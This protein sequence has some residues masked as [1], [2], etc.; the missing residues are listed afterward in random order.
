MINNLKLINWRT[1]HHTELEFDSGTNL[2]IGIMG[3]GKSSIVNALSYGLFG[4]FPALKSKQISLKE[5]IMNRPN[6]QDY[7][8]VGI[9]FT[10]NEKKYF[11]QRL[12]KD[13]GTNQAKLF[14]DNKLIA[15]PKQKDVNEKVEQI[16][17]L[18]YELF[19]RAVYAEQ[20]E[21]DF[22][23]KLNPSERKK[24][25]DELLE[26][27]KYE[28]VRK[29]TVILKN[30]MQKEN[31]QKKEFLIQQKQTIN[32]SEEEKI[33][34]QI[35]A[36]EKELVEINNN[37]NELINIVK[38]AQ[39][40]Y[41]KIEQK[42][43]LFLN[44]KMEIEVLKS[45]LNTLKKSIE[46]YDNNELGFIKKEINNIT[47]FIIERNNEK[48][49]LKQRQENTQASKKKLIEQAS[50]LSYK[51][52]EIEKEIKEITN[53][54]GTCPTCK[55]TLDEKHKKDL[56]NKLKPEIS[57][58][59]EEQNN[60]QS[61]NFDLEEINTKLKNELLKVEKE[62]EGLIKKEYEFEEKQRNIIKNER[63]IKESEITQ[64]EINKKELEI[65]NFE[66]SEDELVNKQNLYFELKNISKLNEEKIKSKNQLK[67]NLEFTL[68]KIKKMNENINLI[69]KEI[70]NSE[71]AI[72]KLGVFENCLIS[73]QIELREELL[74]TI[75]DAL[76]NVW[77]QI[78]PY[79][80][81]L[82]ICLK[83]VENGYDLQV[84]TRNGEWIRVEGILSGGERSAAAIC[85][86]I[87]FS[88]VLTKQLSMLIL[89]EPTHNLDS[90]SIEKLSKMLRDDLPKLVDQIFVITHEKE[91]ETASSAKIYLLNRNKD[92]DEATK[93]EEI[94]TK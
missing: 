19:S 5:I 43:K 10:H 59:V 54:V 90:N 6:K 75:N 89:D 77:K 60:I 23:L 42:Q 48:Q 25:F 28:T 85:I 37:Q 51:E 50:V 22:F 40:D 83:V 9:G 7:T 41:F 64:I 1:H 74:Q 26:L 86:R 24:K 68:N 21:M 3:S 32:D 4:T 47:N 14:E 80:D 16:L 91:L 17:G 35:S 49:T 52:K 53:L 13:E 81:Y 62:L 8:E 70:I 34:Q 30:Q 94:L 58:I 61:K 72:E 82:D 29:N 20:N 71:N 93:I 38:N 18:N 69:Q 56:I 2:I 27:E 33:I 57:R 12:L 39:D 31:K 45:K 55:Q 92:I 76:A 15:G 66:F 36:L 44:K 78:Y 46:S 87:A 84:Q 88:L 79:N 73:T 63:V 11:V 65:K 67:E